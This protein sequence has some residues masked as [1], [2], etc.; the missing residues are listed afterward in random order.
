MNPFRVQL[1]P[2]VLLIRSEAYEGLPPAAQTL[3]GILV[4]C[5]LHTFVPLITSGERDQ[6]SIVKLATFRNPLKAYIVNRKLGVHR[7]SDT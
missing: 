3:D 2:K 4:E 7:H 5:V 1:V 6:K